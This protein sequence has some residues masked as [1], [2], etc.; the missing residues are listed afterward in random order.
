MNRRPRQD[1]RAGCEQ[2]EDRSLL[3]V[4]T[5]AQVRQAYGMNAINFTAN[6][7][8]IPGSGA[9]QM[10]AVVGAYH[11]PFL[12]TV[13]NAFDASFGLSNAA[14]IQVNLAGAQT[15]IGWA[16]EEAM[17]V[18]WSHVMAPGAT[19]IAVEAAS[20]STSDLMNA[21]NLAR[22][23]P[24]VSVVTMSWGGGEFRGQGNYDSFFTTPAGHNG[25]SFVA[26]SGDYGSKYGA[27]WPAT[28]PN[29]VAVGGT[30]LL[31]DAA[32]NTLSETAWSGS[33]GG[34][35]ARTYEPG[36][37]AGVQRSG[38]RS[39]PD[40]SMVADPN[41]GVPVLV[42]TPST[43]QAYWG[44]YGGTSLSTQLFGGLV[45]VVN[46]GRAL[47]G[48]GTLDGPTQTLPLLYSVSSAD[49][50]DVTT[51][52]TGF[53]AT[54][55][56]DLATGLGSPWGPSLVSDLTNPN[57]HA[58]NRSLPSRVKGRTSSRHMARPRIAASSMHV[59]INRLTV[60]TDADSHPRAQEAHHACPLTQ[61]L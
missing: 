26:A 28:S 35:S 39:N 21:V 7:Q 13:L 40:V 2:L 59:T 11:N 51:G 14:V 53:R 54:R 42:M 36:Y 41:T 47:A 23:L 24:G 3:S 37:Q 55:G 18:E 5:P 48:L 6:G 29:V 38:R 17:D 27:N 8:T 31:V 52:S 20:D 46:Q 58:T 4:L 22:Q 1:F 61:G 34:L 45:A 44:V 15:N 50:R 33:G 10:I 43:G 12:S 57:V 19:I 60:A 30:S 49:Y 56:Y 32:G 9:G 16:E 25:V